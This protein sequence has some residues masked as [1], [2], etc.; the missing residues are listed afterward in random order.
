MHQTLFRLVAGS[1]IALGAQPAWAQP[2]AGQVQ[3]LSQLRHRFMFTQ[4]GWGAMGINT[5]AY[6]PGIKPQPLKIGEKT[7]ARGIGHHAPGEILIDLGGQYER[8]ESLAG[9]QPLTA[10]PGSVVFRV[11]VDE[12]E[13]YRSPVVRADSPA[14]KIS[15][16][17]AGAMELRLVV[18]DAGD[19]INSD[20]A[21]WAEARLVKAV[22]PPALSKQNLLDAAHFARVTTSDPAR[23]TG[24]RANRIQEYHAEDVYL[25]SPVYRSPEGWS[26]PR[27]KDGRRC[28]GLNWMERRP[29]REFALQADDAAAPALLTGELQCWVGESAWQGGW[30][31]M[32]T[33]GELRDGW[34]VWSLD[35]AGVAEAQGSTRKLRL[36]LNHPEELTVKA[37]RAFSA[38]ATEQI[39][40]VLQSE[41][42]ALAKPVIEIYNGAFLEPRDSGVGQDLTQPVHLAIRACKKRP[43][44]TERTTL[45]FN[46]APR[47][48][49]GFAVSVDDVLERGAVY[50]PAAGLYVTIDPPKQSLADYKAS[51]KARETVLSMVRRVPDQTREQAMKVVHRR[52]QDMGPMMLSL[53]A[54]N[55][56]V[57]VARDGTITF[58]S[59]P[60]QDPTKVATALDQ[61][62]AVVPMLIGSDKAKLSRKLQGDWMP[63]PVTQ[64]VAGP[65]ACRQRTFVAPAPQAPAAQPE[66]PFGDRPAICVAWFQLENTSDAAA[67]ATLNLHFMHHTGKAEAAEVEIRDGAARAHRLGRLLAWATPAEGLSFLARPGVLQVRGQLKAKQVVEF[68]LYIPTTRLSTQDTLPALQPAEL[69]KATIAHWEAVMAPAMQAELPDPLITNLIKASQVHILL[70]AR[71]EAQG[72]R[73]SAWIASMSYGPLESE[74][75]SVIRGMDVWGHHEF[76]R[77]GLDYFIHRYSPDGM[78]TTGYTLMG[79]GWHLWTLG[80]H[81]RMAADKDWLAARAE[82]VTKLCEWITRQC[83]KT[84]KGPG[85]FGGEPA[86]GPPFYPEAGLM[87]PGV[88][89]DWNAFAHYYCLNAYYYGGLRDTAAALAAT[90]PAKSAALLEKAEQLRKDIREAYAWTQS[91]MPVFVLSD[92][93]AVRGYPSQVY[94]P[95]PTADLFPGQ[96]ANRSWCYDV[97]LGAHQLVPLGVLASD[98][99]QVEDMMQHMEDVQFLSEGWFD[100]PAAENHKDPFNFGGFAKVQPYYCRNAEIYALRDDVKP[101]VRSYFNTIPSL[102]NTEVLWFQEHFKGVAAWNKTHE[103]GYFL[104]QSKVMLVQERG[105]ELWLAPLLTD[106]WYQDGKAIVVRNAPTKFGPTAYQITSY[107][108]EGHVDASIV[109][110][111]RSMPKA[112]VLRV[113]H[114]E[115]KPILKA[116]VNGHDV[117]RI[118]NQRQCVWMKPEKNS[119]S[120]RLEYRGGA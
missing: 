34:C 114:P 30:K 28:I 35:F 94:G 33:K 17:V 47:F 43:W 44:K 101:F 13:A 10:S 115:G 5:C 46:P 60:E 76:A 24:S 87:P 69:L 42:E 57:I 23:V 7:Y 68:P 77:R 56:K 86:E 22:N 78:L 15:V 105:E 12:K 14:Q 80:E 73:I 2:D 20:C 3:E 117:E 39:K 1:L 51:L 92:G 88:M 104:H 119:M 52:E 95:G 4:Q 81:C 65:I 41:G 25:E 84:R 75:H 113:R 31:A 72:S 50:V 21:N 38:S 61:S 89:A 116:Q 103:T 64:T 91:R 109:T 63:I 97:E 108:A 70:A 32:G 59:N 106:A 99:P 62:C 9:L 82:P 90:D 6:A 118:D 36:I 110:P 37:I 79:M 55:H 83:D 53:A 54:D 26:V 102:L 29:I 19:G 71:N 107:V 85:M 111:T 11:L 16:S 100:Y 18:D 98:E 112:I 58:S 8:F 120:V 40:L 48:K 49:D 96:D 27:H 74:A 67:E 93:T 45:L 66:A